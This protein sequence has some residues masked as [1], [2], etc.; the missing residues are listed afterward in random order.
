M[1]G[2]ALVMGAVAYDPKVVTIWDGFRAWLRDHGLAFDYVLYSNYERQVDELLSGRIDA[3]WNSPLAWIRAQR[4]GAAAGTPVEAVTMRDSDRDLTSVVV[5]RAG[6]GISA[7]SDLAGKVVATGAIDSPQSTLIPL[8]YLRANG[9]LPGRDVDVRRFDVGVG[10]H[11]DH[12]GGER[13]AARALVAGEVDAACMIDGNHLAFGAEGTLPAGATAVIGQTDRFDHC[14]MTVRTDGPRHASARFNEL[15]LGMSYGDAEVRPLL[16]LEG[17]K[18]W[19]EG[20]TSGYGLLDRAVS[21][22]GFYDDEGRIGDGD[23]R[24]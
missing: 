11:G 16:D 1:S 24:P 12:I 8:S 14:N 23:Y 6:S 7:V 19:A 4:I 15:L 21:E 13:D 9:L 2:E 22:T 20:R 5:A 18:A 10:L 17:L 3:A